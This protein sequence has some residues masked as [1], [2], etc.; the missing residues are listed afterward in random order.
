MDT[1]EKIISRYII[2]AIILLDEKMIPNP[3]K[4]F[5]TICSNCHR[6]IHRKKNDIITPEQLKKIIQEQNSN[7]VK[8]TQLMYKFDIE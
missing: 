7:N 6:M 8:S 5:V 2:K 1:L 3:E 4:D